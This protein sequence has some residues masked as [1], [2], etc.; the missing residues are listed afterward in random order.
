VTTENQES[1][2]SGSGDFLAPDLVLLLLRAGEESRSSGRI[3]GITRLEKLLFL[4]A[5]EQG[6]DDLVVDP[7]EFKPYHYGPYSKEIYEAVELLEEAGLVE[8][9]RFIGENQLDEA[10]ELALDVADELGVE[11]RFLLTPTGEKVA[12]LLASRM[13][14]AFTKLSSVKRSYGN[15]SLK[16]LIRYVYSKY[17]EYA[18]ESVIRE[19]MT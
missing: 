13:P 8:E 15:L 2:G 16:R 6:V 14:E 1:S 3:N 7:F 10:E 11:R 12:D 9:E 4:A 18:E 17:P 5:K 19:S